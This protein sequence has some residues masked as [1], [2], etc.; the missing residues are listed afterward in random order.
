MILDVR[1][2][3]RFRDGHH[4]EAASVPL[5]ELAARMH[6]LPP[7]G[8]PFAIFDDDPARA[9]EAVAFLAA[10]GREVTAIEGAEG[11]SHVD[12]SDA[13]GPATARLWRCHPALDE[14]LPLIESAW[15]D[16][17]GR[18]AVDLACGAGRDA[19]V[20]AEAGLDLE[21][22]DLLPDA[23]AK[24]DDLARRAGV[25]IRT[26]VADLADGAG[27]AEASVDLV[28]VF[29]FLRRSLFDEIRRAVTPGGF[30]LW[31]TY[32]EEQRRRFGKPRKA[33]SLLASGELREAFAGWE[34]VIDREGER[35]PRMVTATL[36][37]RKPAG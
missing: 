26:R 10:R 20:L 33:R 15:G 9:A 16:L 14:A 7:R 35:G 19:V 37:A 25:T 29:R 27:L 24:A 31:D 4:P 8:E 36:L 23:L 18:R 12:A 17:A 13:K 6:E 28:V 1:P 22:V 32:T 2:E 30:V 5:E 11:A 21:A 3:G 34:A